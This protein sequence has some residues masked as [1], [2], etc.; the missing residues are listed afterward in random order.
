MNGK[1]PRTPPVWP[2]QALLE[3]YLLGDHAWGKLRLLSLLMA[4]EFLIAVG[5]L[6]FASE[7][8]D[9]IIEQAVALFPTLSVLPHSLLQFLVSLLPLLGL[10]YWIV[11]FLVIAAG[12][13]I[14]ARFV[15]DIYELS[16]YRQAFRYLFASMFAIN[17]PHLLIA[18]G[19]RSI[20]E[21]ETNPLDVIGGPGYV[22]IQPGNAVLFERLDRPSNVMG[23][24]RHYISRFERIK[25]IVDLKEREVTIALAGA[26]TKDRIEIN[27]RDIYFRYQLWT[28]MKEKDSRRRIH[29]I[30]YS[31]SVGA[32]RD[33]VYNRT[34]TREGIQDWDT[35]VRAVIENEIGGYIRKHTLDELMLPHNSGEHPRDRIS[36]VLASTRVR[37][38][39]K[40]VGVRLLWWDIGHFDIAEKQVDEQM[41]N[42]W[43]ARWRGNAS[44]LRETW[45]AQRQSY[46]DLGRAEAQ[47]ELLTGIIQS[48]E[49]LNLPADSSRNLR[50]VI[51]LH[52]S[53][54]L[55]S[56]ASVYQLPEEAKLPDKGKRA[57]G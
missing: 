55:E 29:S 53:R 50:N 12:L 8:I 49:A 9:S 25:E 6:I 43:K 56:M 13:M 17:Y 16:D 10:R 39:L 41:L 45:Q 2:F 14:G 24:G 3:K 47:A 51:L 23:A 54:I 21:G 40:R 1:A 15:Q 46:Q 28:S 34:V 7:K 38:R 4:A 37:N 26:M 31:Y 32:I 57:D 11:P 22:T 19:V 44:L 52:A 30:P 27:I 33:M 18:D 48:L 5:N 42:A 35:A 20:Q 36:E